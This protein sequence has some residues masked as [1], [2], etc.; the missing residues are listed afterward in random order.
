MQSINV[1]PASSLTIVTGK[2][3]PAILDSVAR[4]AR[5]LPPGNGSSLRTH[6]SGRIVLG[7]GFRLPAARAVG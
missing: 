5:P 4:E 7:G 2:S 1:V 6:D 3:E